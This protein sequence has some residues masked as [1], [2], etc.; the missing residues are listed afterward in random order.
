MTPTAVG[1]KEQM[2][3]FDNG[4]PSK[5]RP[6]LL[7]QANMN[8]AT[9]TVCNAGGTS[10]QFL[11]RKRNAVENGSPMG[12]SL[13]DLQ[14]QV[15]E[16]AAG[17][18]PTPR[19]EDCEQTGAH[20]GKPDTL[21]SAARQWP[22]PNAHDADRGAESAETK[23]NRGAGGVNLLQTVKEAKD[24]Q[25]PS[26]TLASAAATRCTGAR[27]GELLLGGQVRADWNTP[28]VNDSKNDTLPP[29][30]RQRDSIC[31]DI[32]G[33][34]D[35]EKRSTSGKSRGSLN[36]RWTL[37]LM[38]YPADWCDLPPDTIERLCARRATPSCPPS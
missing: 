27:K 6:T 13:T 4:D 29:S 21:T 32:L 34:Q 14:M 10:E 37:Q 38:G 23:K 5:P 7:A 28:T 11:Q 25:T 18:W 24:W 20:T 16:V 26:A 33:L 1:A 8:W 19:A 36:G 9:P 12:I 17:N 30:Q 22:T 35:P 3:T 2:Y 15:N 31:G